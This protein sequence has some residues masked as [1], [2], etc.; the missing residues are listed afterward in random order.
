MSHSFLPSNQYL[1]HKEKSPCPIR[2]L[3]PFLSISKAWRIELRGCWVAW[4]IEELQRYLSL[5]IQT[6]NLPGSFIKALACFLSREMFFCLAFLIPK[7]PLLLGLVIVT[8]S[9]Q[10]EALEPQIKP[11]TIVSIAWQNQS[12]LIPLW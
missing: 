12:H 9:T 7:P 11:L 10:W 1:N 8:Q 4:K 5:R 2:K 6:H 3:K